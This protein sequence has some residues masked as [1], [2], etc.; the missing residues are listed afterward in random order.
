MQQNFPILF[1]N[2]PDETLRREK[3]FFCET[4]QFIAEEE[5]ATRFAIVKNVF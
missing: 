4:I 1:E 5:L 3:L 2:I